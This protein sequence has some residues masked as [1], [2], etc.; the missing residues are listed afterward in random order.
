M[1]TQGL[2]ATVSEPLLVTGRCYL[3]LA[4]TLLLCGPLLESHWV[5]E[6]MESW[7]D[8]LFRDG[9]DTG[10]KIQTV[11]RT[12][13]ALFQFQVVIS[14]SSLGVPHPL[15]TW[16]TP[17]IQCNERSLV[18]CYRECWGA[19]ALKGYHCCLGLGNTGLAWLIVDTRLNYWGSETEMQGW[20]AAAAHTPG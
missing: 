4:L 2:R 13:C 6:Q 15:M 9:G 10:W 7:L 16:A 17:Y 5:D 8:L 3:Y 14:S 11:H 20:M 18:W 19:S 1:Y 12:Q